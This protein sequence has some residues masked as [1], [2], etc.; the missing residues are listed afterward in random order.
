M[1]SYIVLTDDKGA[2][3]IDIQLLTENCTLIHC[4]ENNTSNVIMSIGGGSHGASVYKDSGYCDL[5]G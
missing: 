3:L 1:L 2:E 4:M 5:S